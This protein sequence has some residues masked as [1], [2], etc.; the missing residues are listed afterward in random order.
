MNKRWLIVCFM[1]IAVLCSGQASAFQF[2]YPGPD[3][4]SAGS[5]C[6]VML[7]G[8]L[9]TPVVTPTTPGASLSTSSFDAIASGFSLTTALPLGPKTIHWSV[10]DQVGNSH[11]FTF[12]VLIADRTAPVLN[13]GSTPANVTY[14]SIAQVPAPQSFT[15]SDNCTPSANIILSFDEQNVPAL[16]AA[17]VMTR[18][19]T[20]IDAAGNSSKFTQ[21]ILI[22]ADNFP[23]QITTFPSSTFQTCSQNMNP[24]YQTWLNLQMNNF[25]ATDASSSPVLTNSGPANFPP[26]CA[27]N[28]VVT[29][30][31]TDA[32]NNTST[33][34][35]TYSTSDTQKPQVITDARDSIVYCVSQSNH[36]NALAQW[37][38][39]RAR[40]LAS[41]L[42]TPTNQLV[43]FMEINGNVQDSAQVVAAFLQS[44]TQGCQAK[45]VGS[46]VVMR[47][48]GLVDVD[49]Y[50]RDLCNNT[51]H[52]GKASFAAVDTTKPQITPP[53][54]GIQPC[55]GAGNNAAIQAWV[56]NH[57]AATASDFCSDVYWSN[58]FTWRH[59]NG[60]FGSGNTA[61][62]PYPTV[63]LDSCAWWFDATFFATDAC[64]NQDSITI[65]YDMKDLVPP[66]FT[67][68]PV[69][70]TFP[71][72]T[73]IP[74]GYTTPIFDACSAG[75]LV[76]NYVATQIAQPC[77]GTTVYRM[78]W[79]ATD[80]CGNIATATSQVVI[81]D[82]VGPEFVQ[83]PAPY[84]VSCAAFV[85]PPASANITMVDACSGVT[86]ITSDTTNT[87]N[88]DSTTCGFSN[89]TVKRVFIATDG[90]GNT[91]TA[92]QLITVIDTTG[93]VFSGFLDTLIN[94][95]AIAD[96]MTTNFPLPTARDACNQRLYPIQSVNRT[97]TAANC[98][99][100]YNLTLRWSATDACSNTSTFIQLVRAR[101][102]IAPS[103]VGI[104][105]NTT[106]DCIAIPVAP[107]LGT[108]LA[109]ADNCDTDIN[110]LLNETEIRVPDSTN[111][112]HYS[113]ELRRSW[114]ATDNCGNFRT[115]SQLLTV[116]DSTPPRIFC[117][118]N[119][120]VPNLPGFC[121]ALT[122]IP[123]PLA[124]FDECSSALISAQLI[125][126][127]PIV[128]TSGLPNNSAV[129]DTIRFAFS[130]PNFS[131][132]WPAST[133][134]SL[135]IA[136]RK[137]DAEQPDEH[138]K[139]FGEKNTYLGI[140]SP[141]ASQCG[142]GVTN[143][144]IPI[145]LL[146]DWLMD[147]N[148]DLV[149]IPN[150][151]GPNA[152]NAICPSGS[153]IADIRYTYAKPNIPVDVTYQLNQQA[154]QP[155][156]AL[157]NLQLPVGQNQVVYTASDCSGNTSS[158]SLTVEILD[159]EGPS[160]TTS[161][162][163]RFMAGPNDCV[164]TVAIPA[165]TNFNDN[166]TLG[167]AFS[168]SSPQQA[169]V[170]QS[171]PNAGN[172]PQD[173]SYTFSNTPANIF[174]A[175]QL[176]FSFLG[177]HSDTG[178]F[179]T[180][181]SENGANIGQTSLSPQD[182]QCI[183]FH[184]S[185]F[186]EHQDSIRKWASDGSMT[187]KAVAN[188][189][190]GS[191]TEFI[192]PCD[193]LNTQMTDGKSK[194]FISI[195]Y[196]A[197]AFDFAV[198]NSQQAVVQ[199]GTMLGRVANISLPVG[200]YKLEYRLNDPSAN[201]SLRSTILHV[202]D[203]IAPLA[204]CKNSLIPVDIGGNGTVNLVPSQVNNQSTDNC[205]IA[206]MQ[207]T[208]T[209]FSCSQSGN[210][211][212]VTLTVM[213]TSGNTATCSATVQIQT[214]G[215]APSY[216]SG[217]CVNQNLELF[218]NATNDPSQTFSYQWTG[219]MQFTSQI[220][221][222][223]IPMASMANEGTY[224]LTATNINGCSATASLFVSLIGQPQVPIIQKDKPSYCQGEQ[225]MLT[226]QAYGGASAS[227][228]WF[229][230]TPGSSTLLGTTTAPQWI[231]SAASTGQ[232][233]YYVI[234]SVNNCASAP[235]APASVLVN[236]F[237][238]AQV[239]QTAITVCEGMAVQLQ[240]TNA[241]S[242][243]TFNWTGP[244]FTSS[245]QQAIVTTQAAGVHQG[246]Y[247]LIVSANGCNS[248]PVAVQVN[249]K[250]RPQ[251]PVIASNSPLCLNET[252]EFTSTATGVNSYHW[253]TPLQDTIVT[254][255]A[256]LQ[257]SPQP[258]YA[259]VWQLYV[260]QNGCPSAKSI[261]ASV[262]I[263]ALPQV[264]AVANT[265]VCLTNVLQL[266]AQTISPNLNFQWTGP[267]GFSTLTQNPISNPI[268]GSYIVTAST[269]LAGCQ[270]RDT[271]EVVAVTNPVITSVTSNAPLCSTG[272]TDAQLFAVIFP[273][274][275]AYTYQWTGPN[276][277]ASSSAQPTIPNISSADVGQYHLTVRD[278]FGC[279]SAPYTTTVQTNNAPAIPDL[280]PVQ[281]MCA[282]SNLEILIQNTA[283]Y[284]GAT[285][286]YVWHTP[287]NGVVTTN[288]PSFQKSNAQVN[289]NGLYWVEVVNGNCVS[290]PSALINVV[291]NAIPA[292]PAISVNT[293]LCEG[294][295]LRFNTSVTIGQAWQ[296]TG[297]GAFTS[298]VSNPVIPQVVSSLHS[299]PYRVRYELNGCQSA[300]S[301]IVLVDVLSRPNTPVILQS[302]PVC[303]DIPGATL[304][305]LISPNTATPNATY[306][307]FAGLA[308][309]P[310]DQPVFGTQHTVDSL[311]NFGPGNQVFY[312]VATA[313]GCRSF[314]S[315][316]VYVMFDTIPNQAAYA[317]NDFAQCNQTPIQLNASAPQI[318][319]GQWSQPAN[320]GLVI[321]T[322]TQANSPVIGG[323]A[324]VTYKFYWNLSNG[325]CINYSTDTVQVQVRAFEAASS[326]ATIDSCFAFEASLMAQPDGGSLGF[327]AQPIS[328]S[329]LDV[330][331]VNPND[332]NTRVTGIEP[333]N[334][335][336]FYWTLP[337]IGCGTSVDTTTVRSIGT[338][339]I[340]GTDKTICAFDS[341]A[342]LSA[343]P[344]AAFETGAWLS[345]N[346]VVE[347]ASK[348]SSSTTACG[349]RP[350]DNIFVWTTNNGKCGHR[351]VDTLMLRFEPQPV[352]LPDTIR[353]PFGEQATFSVLANDILPASIAEEAVT[354]P[355]YGTLTRIDR[356]VYKYI[357]ELDRTGFQLFTYQVC[358]LFCADTC[359]KQIVALEVL[360]PSDC[361]VPTIITPNDDEVNDFF[362]VPCLESDTFQ[363]NEVLIFNSNGDKVFYA[364]P[365]KNDWNGK[366]E[367]GSELTAGTYFFIVKYNGTQK[368]VSGFLELRR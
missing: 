251:Q 299:G 214:S 211:F 289:D 125:D 185:T 275:G 181:F 278:T 329:L 270:T 143:L 172:I 236:A 38:R 341:C 19:W 7:Q 67:A 203:T 306:Q 206:S 200:A 291:I 230:G 309:N 126:T 360:E 366:G 146:N 154:P 15:A 219:P 158:C 30:S 212:P 358:N 257:L 43:W 52:L 363:D 274:G 356:G 215:I 268:A 362:F 168:A 290:Q 177:D 192:H 44:M 129:V 254:S 244:N 328:Q 334:T 88:P 130:A 46:Q 297:P 208:P 176:S 190:A 28:I 8:Q 58:Y 29:F 133:Q 322:P 186:T 332:P 42:C 295:T 191:F 252:L 152:I 164:A 25:A 21:T 101:D 137:A 335:Y 151:T 90:C 22:T 102:T 174:G 269:P 150:G 249:V 265:P 104:P 169:I 10:S 111:C 27:Q 53:P 122:N 331:I 6:T 308:Q 245:L 118:G 170:F 273:Q 338:E 17:G 248:L 202:I 14:M 12:T 131:G 284:Q 271:V 178:E 340:A 187:F 51:Q 86:S 48:R 216:L 182:S 229:E 69:V 359:P 294:D 156:P 114:I 96:P 221:N 321:S 148:L 100:N 140:T 250:L 63:P 246:V 240:S 107:L 343:G 311:G 193:N 286:S 97:I 346:P 255:V 307:W 167:S 296:W 218:A 134:A 124:I 348:S 145:D 142:D 194:W 279:L 93:P 304:P 223:V 352:L 283:A 210:N 109:A 267:N 82:K 73:G 353:I 62:G 319:Q 357:P 188:N 367:N 119:I 282:G 11:T 315:A 127:L 77:P 217:V 3:T 226:T 70:D 198:K 23:P 336:T 64:G 157:N 71:C 196:Q 351:S 184:T 76:V 261:G 301:D 45:T 195:G 228:S 50:V 333:G 9:G 314:T 241:P 288:N 239:A 231:I 339:A 224:L 99:D 18:T 337:D 303:I 89:Y 258:Q 105:A 36:I 266:S 235:S 327:W 312:V 37:I 149:F 361:V 47:V 81:Q 238:I 16:C 345:L 147:G 183:A 95:S 237:P 287:V 120:V 26:G 330:V 344:L 233:N 259:G 132:N 320:Q 144:F 116:R 368:E 85:L 57:G 60:F 56:Q 39:L 264:S 61:S 209:Q 66:V 92:S 197:V 313:D 189:D 302:N 136:L 123:I 159:V 364:S 78:N 1:P 32:C 103:L 108:G 325:G 40:S 225:I 342:T 298:N 205:G 59:R 316:P 166:C 117:H 199:S 155:F 49:F 91:S 65:R 276:G 347:I 324:G 323:L 171:D 84:S 220:A 272:N 222:P 5:G 318:G 34:Q 110:V 80:R 293:P 33:A 232:R 20:A 263:E 350:G 213:D 175:G 31:A 165:P 280:A 262:V 74:P 305:L 113:Y 106:V 128:N 285:V 162:T 180:I 281:Q 135:Q 41:D 300:W 55:L 354:D 98:A 153:V 138:F 201:S 35:A 2:M 179:F 292:T 160:F 141:T 163:L 75:Q 253:V 349:L 94:C 87:Q 355:Q 72:L 112:D 207:L 161:D 326:V 83:V 173:L 243:L 260:S 227:Y 234:A 365:Y 277:F 4:I 68:L 204:K 139:V 54:V 317:G 242:N 256:N 115:Y 13:T 247:Q 79:T 24:A 310:V 121:F